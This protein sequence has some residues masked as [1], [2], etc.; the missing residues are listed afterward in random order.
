MASQADGPGGDGS[1]EKGRRV[2]SDPVTTP[3]PPP[4]EGDTVGLKRPER[5]ERWGTTVA[6]TKPEDKDHELIRRFTLIVTAGPDTG[7]R[8]VSSGERMVIG[9]HNSADMV[10]KDPTVSRF[11]CDITLTAKAVLIR[12]LDSSNGTLVDG[13]AIQQA[14]LRGGSVLTLGRTQVRFDTGGEPVRVPLG[15][16]RFGVMVGGSAVM[17]RVFAHLERAAASDAT[18]LLEGETGTGK[19]AAAESIH[20]ESQRKNGPFIVVDCG[21]IPPDL[22]ESEIF[23]H[24]KGAFTGAVA[25]REGAFEAA[26]QGTIFLDEIGE[27]TSDLQ[28]KLLRVLE[29]RE[30][31]PVGTNKVIPVDVRVIAATN[32]NLKA[33]VNAR[34]FR[35]DLYY[36]L[37]VLE[38]RLP[39]LRERNDDLPE[40]IEHILA[41]LGAEK[42]READLLRS[43]DFLVELSRHAWPGNVRELRNYIERCLAL[44]EQTPLSP[45]PQD[46]DGS[47]LLDL[48]KPLK[49]AREEWTRAFERRYL[50]ALLRAHSGNVAAAARGAGVDRIH[51]YRLLWR[52]GLK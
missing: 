50:E 48:D 51:L 37:G 34:R 46:D 2:V 14:F 16:A 21:A 3:P 33:E 40:L 23:G 38:I 9:T 36:R 7:Q 15:K 11:H 19:E 4:E 12:D 45:P 22:L 43:R 13:V 18:V 30:V 17:R 8:F 6:T 24:E 20:R 41:S 35:S 28:P 49:V 52:H 27:L 1:D 42:K 32:R 44:R 29:K 10:L 31:K 5:S 26:D 25:S 39:P 47:S